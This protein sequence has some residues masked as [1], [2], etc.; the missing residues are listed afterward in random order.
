MAVTAGGG[1]DSS[2]RR[3]D[4]PAEGPVRPDSEA[5]EAG[6]QSPLPGVPTAERTASPSVIPS[7]AA[8]SPSGKEPRSTPGPGGSTASASS[9]SS[10]DA[11]DS[12]TDGAAKPGSGNGGGS[13]EVR[14]FPLA[15]EAS[16]KCL[17]GAG[18][19][20]QLVASACDGSSGQSWSP[21]PDGSLRQGGFCATLTGTEDRTPVVLA[22]C[23]RSSAQRISLSGTALVSAS[24]G[25]CLDLF[26][27]ASGSQIVLWECNG[28]DNQRWR[29]A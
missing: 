10:S 14:A 3:A 9:G 11:D 13:T 28:R 5:E 26:G 27:G 2:S 29:A 12:G 23:N 16:G 6:G 1:S 15:V 4:A 7:A 17:T 8:S 21:G 20:A 25:K 24:T 22:G 18:S 19:G